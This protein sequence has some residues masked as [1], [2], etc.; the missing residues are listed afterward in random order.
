M[1]V[2]VG[3]VSANGEGKNCGG[4]FDEESLFST[5]TNPQVVF[6]AVAGEEEA[7]DSIRLSDVVDNVAGEHFVKLLS[8]FK[9]CIGQQIVGIAKQNFAI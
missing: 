9:R 1:L 4:G 6:F 8:C 7:S 5:D 3:R 2:V